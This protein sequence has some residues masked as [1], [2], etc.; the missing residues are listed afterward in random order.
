MQK[1]IKTSVIIPIFNTEKY[2]DECIQSVLNQTQKEIEIILVDDGSTDHSGE[3]IDRYA[4]EYGNVVVIHQDN[5]KLGAARNNGFKVAK[6]KYVYFMDSDDYIAEDLLEKCYALAEQRNLEVVFFD[7]H[8][9]W[10]ENDSIRSDGSI[11][12]DRSQKGIKDTVFGGKEYWKAYYKCGGVITCAPFNYILK[13]YIEHNEL[14]FETGVFYEDNDWIARMHVKA[15]RIY[16]YPEKLYYRRYRTGSI[17]QNDYSITHFESAALLFWKLIYLSKNEED[18]ENRQIYG[19]MLQSIMWRLQDILKTIDRGII[20]GSFKRFWE[21]LLDE[22]TE[23]NFLDEGIYIKVLMF[24]KDIVKRYVV[25]KADDGA[26]SKYEDIRNRICSYLIK[27]YQLDMDVNVGIYG[28]G[29]MCDEIFDWYERNN[30]PI[31]ANIC[32]IA[33]ESATNSYKGYPVYNIRQA[34]EISFEHIIIA[35]TKYADEMLE[36]LKQNN[37]NTESCFVTISYLGDV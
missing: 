36:N 5:Q 19:D 33:T 10:E 37:I 9:F 35:S 34:K 1:E 29:K 18:F 4:R 22:A 20:A 8:A 17:T 30:V 25:I 28:M 26:M 14:L 15:K 21:K 13:E 23:L 12:Y 24:L 27:N 3:I 32:F 31:N 2:L 7:A 6:G 11:R 16:Y